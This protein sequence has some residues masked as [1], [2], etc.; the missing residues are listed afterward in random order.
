MKIRL[1][2]AE[3]FNADRRTD[4][5]RMVR[6]D[7]ANIRF[8]QFCELAQKFRSYLRENIICIVESDHCCLGAITHVVCSNDMKYIDVPCGK[9]HP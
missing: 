3:L 2:V 9:I 7:E 4:N 1:V 8:S 5:G 6:H